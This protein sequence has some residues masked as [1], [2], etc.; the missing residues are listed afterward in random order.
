[1]ASLKV[2]HLQGRKKAQKHNVS[3]GG[4]NWEFERERAVMA[5]LQLV[6]LQLHRLWEPPVAEEEFVK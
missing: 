4:I 6:Q 2:V 5:L 1:M 3:L